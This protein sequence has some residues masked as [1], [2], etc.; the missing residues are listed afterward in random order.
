MALKQQT[1]AFVFSN[2]DERVALNTILLLRTM[3][4]DIRVLVL[5]PSVSHFVALW[6]VP[7]IQPT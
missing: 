5:I 6:T 7:L 4:L 2:T 3:A 1:I